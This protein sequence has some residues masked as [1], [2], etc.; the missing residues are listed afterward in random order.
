M[1]VT[2]T[3]LQDGKPNVAFNCRGGTNLRQLLIAKCINVY[4]SLTRWT[5]CNGK[6]R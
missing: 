1:T 6:Q 5:S 3:V 4:R 2:V